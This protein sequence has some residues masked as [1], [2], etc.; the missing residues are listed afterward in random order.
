ML[1]SG[2]QPSCPSQ[3]DCSIEWKLKRLVN[4]FTSLW[5]TVN[6]GEGYWIK[7]L[8]N[9]TRGKGVASMTQCQQP[10]GREEWLEPLRSR[11]G[12]VGHPSTSRGSCWFLLL[13]FLT[14]SRLSWPIPSSVHIDLEPMLTHPDSESHGNWAGPCGAPGHA[15]L[16]VSFIS[17]LWGTNSS[18]HDL[19]RVLKGVLG[20]KIHP[21][22]WGSL[23]WWQSDW[24]W[25]HLLVGFLPRLSWVRMGS[26]E[27]LNG[28]SLQDYESKIRW[29]AGGARQEGSRP[30]CWWFQ[31]DPVGLAAP[32]I[33]ACANTYL[34]SYPHDT[35][36]SSQ[37]PSCLELDR[38]RWL[39]LFPVIFLFSNSGGIHFLVQKYKSFY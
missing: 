29:R 39:N 31:C 37:T 33:P 16:L 23:G 15:C 6:T 38:L 5:Y 3:D 28:R 32:P 27:G 2:F 7:T 24:L 30:A 10:T 1:P 12:T 9:P 11:L 26:A 17:C 19:P 22:H 36:E 14:S 34:M 13:A 8:I 21:R 4:R 35:R 25:I 20:F 18:L